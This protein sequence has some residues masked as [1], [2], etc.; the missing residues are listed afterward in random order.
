MNFDP[1][2]NQALS[3]AYWLLAIALVVT[4]FKSPWFKGILGEELVKFFGRLRLPTDVYH[5]I[6]NVTLQTPDGTTQIEHIFASRFG[7]FNIWGQRNI[8]VRVTFW[9]LIYLINYTSIC[10]SAPHIPIS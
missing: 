1:L 9:R 10:Y 3:V 2:I 6:H 8:G 5:R 4:I 7:I